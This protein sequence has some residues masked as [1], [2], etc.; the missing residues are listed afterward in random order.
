MGGRVGVNQHTDRVANTLPTLER[1]KSADIA[2]EAVGMSGETMKGFEGE[3][4][5]NRMN[6][7]NHG[8]RK[9][10]KKFDIRFGWTWKQSR[11]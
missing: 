5:L 4:C 2:A 3:K 9:W 7:P 11:A 8:G 6:C 10:Q 1:G